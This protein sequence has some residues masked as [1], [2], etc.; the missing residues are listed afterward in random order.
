MTP[1]ERLPFHVVLDPQMVLWIMDAV[2][3]ETGAPPAGSLR[4][5]AG[6]LWLRMV[7]EGIAYGQLELEEEEAWTLDAR[8]HPNQAPWAVDL[9]TQIA[10]VI[11][12]R[13][14]KVGISE[15]RTDR[16]FDEVRKKRSRG[17]GEPVGT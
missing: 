12:E 16:S 15:D 8:L 2:K 10:R 3:T 5:K 7:D 4:R 6:A 11:W 9:L 14:F 1:E 13:E 17:G